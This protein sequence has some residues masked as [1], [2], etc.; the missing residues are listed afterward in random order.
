M[1]Y[2]KPNSNRYKNGEVIEKKIV[3]VVGGAKLKKKS[4]LQ[5]IYE[6]LIT[7]DASKIKDYIVC[8]VLVPSIKKTIDS[9]VK[10]SLD[11]FLYG[12]S[13]SSGN[14]KN[15]SRISYRDYYD[16][17]DRSN[18][19]R[20]IRPDYN[21]II[22]DNRSQAERV[23]EEM[24][25]ILDKYDVVTISDL[26]QLVGLPDE[27]T[28]NDYGWTNLAN[29]SVDRCREGYAIRLPRAIYIK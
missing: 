27:Y 6:G 5:A 26:Y 13:R 16:R 9:I 18:N 29:A 7:E 3:P 11:M 15:T 23:L 22:L 24:E 14:S 25:N 21:N 8:D 19:T 20:R 17:D 2:Y 4:S 10:G 28:D 1:D 12:E